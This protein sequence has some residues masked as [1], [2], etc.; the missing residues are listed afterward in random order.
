V[1]ANAI[2]YHFGSKAQLYEQIL[3]EFVGDRLGAAERML[4]AAP[5][6]SVELRVRLQLFCDETLLAMLTEPE[7]LAIAFFELQNGFRHGG[8]NVADAIRQHEQRL[9]DFL[10]SAR[11]RGLVK[12]EI[13]V[14]IVSGTLLERVVNQAR[15]VDLH[16][17]LWGTTPVSDDYRKHWVEQLVDLCLY[18]A[19][20]SGTAPRI[21]TNM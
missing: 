17:N 6:D 4:S 10:E 12:D 11:T 7:V 3:E 15:F 8:K 13:D 16:E 21:P 1:N 19:A 14:A 9:T 2:H 18:A 20:T 5:V